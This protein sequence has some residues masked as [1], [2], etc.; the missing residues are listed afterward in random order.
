M[1][2]SAS[3]RHC[4]SKSAEQYPNFATGAGAA[5]VAEKIGADSC[6]SDERGLQLVV[7]VTPPPRHRI[8]VLLDENSP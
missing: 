4:H 8:G 7:L 6:C 3:V 2:Q 5:S 1:R